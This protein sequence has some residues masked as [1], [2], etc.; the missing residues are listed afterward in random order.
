M[1]RLAR[2]CNCFEAQDRTF[3]VASQGAFREL[4][5]PQALEPEM[6]VVGN[7]ETMLSILG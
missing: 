4:P 6:C 3:G 1:V 2:G 5:S 7:A